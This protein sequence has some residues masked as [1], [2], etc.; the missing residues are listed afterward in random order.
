MSA[1]AQKAQKAQ[2]APS[3]AA[4]VQT[5]ADTCRDHAQMSA[6]L[7][8]CTAGTVGRVAAAVGRLQL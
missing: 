7:I 2:K 4:V 5:R 8:A 3:L 1:S 6:S